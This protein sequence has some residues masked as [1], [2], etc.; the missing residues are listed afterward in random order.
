MYLDVRVNP[1]LLMPSQTLSTLHSLQYLSMEYI[2]S[3]LDTTMSDFDSLTKLAVFYLY[4]YSN[5]T[6]TTFLPLAGLPI[7]MLRLL[8]VYGNDNL[9]DKTVF[10]PFSSVRNV[11]TDF[12]ALL[13]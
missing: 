1:T 4:F 13:L 11:Y 5:I 3:T 2:G 12:R 8:P 9:I 7:Q 6:N 10:V